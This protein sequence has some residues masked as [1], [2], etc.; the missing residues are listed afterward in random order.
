MGAK[1]AKKMDT[2]IQL[3]KDVCMSVSVCVCVCVYVMRDEVRKHDS[4]VAGGHFQN[5]HISV[6]LQN[7]QWNVGLNIPGYDSFCFS[8]YSQLQQRS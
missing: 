8:V 4:A 5:S 7:I 3:E 2:N 1:L 6:F